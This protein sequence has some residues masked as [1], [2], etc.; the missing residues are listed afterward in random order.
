MIEKSKFSNG[1]FMVAAYLIADFL[2]EAAGTA[3][4]LITN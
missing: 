2:L 4:T 1:R 3:R